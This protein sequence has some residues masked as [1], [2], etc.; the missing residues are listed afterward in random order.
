[1]AFWS[2][3]AQTF[4]NAPKHW[5]AVELNPVGIPGADLLAVAVGLAEVA[6][7]PGNGMA[8]LR[9]FVYDDGIL[10][11]P[12]VIE[13][14]GKKTG[15]F[16]YGA[17]HADPAGH[18]T[19]ARSLLR[20]RENMNAV[21][22]AS[23]SVAPAKP[24]M[25]LEPIDTPFFRKPE[26][27]PGDASYSLWWSTPEDP[28]FTHSEDRRLL[29]RWFAALDG[30]GWLLFTAFLRDL[31]LA[32]LEDKKPVAMPAQPFLHPLEGPGE[33]SLLLH[34]GENEGAFLAFNEATTT[35][36]RRRT[37]LRLLANFAETYREAI[38]A[39]SIP[40]REQEQGQ[41]TWAG[42]RDR[43]LEQEAT[44]ASGLRVHSIDVKDGQ[45]VR[46][47]HAQTAADRSSRPALPSRE[48]LDFAMDLVDRVVARIGGAT[49]G[50]SDQQLGQPNAFPTMAVRAG[51]ALYERQLPYEDAEMAQGAAARLLDEWP[52]LEVAALLLD[53]AIRENGHRVDIFSVVVQNRAEGSTA[54][55]IQRY[56]SSGGR[57]ELL[58]NPS[59]SSR[60]PFLDPKTED[61]HPPDP[62]LQAFTEEIVKTIVADLTIL[63]P[64][65]MLGDDPQAVL[66]TPSAIL[67]LGAA[68]ERPRNIRFMLQGPIIAAMSCARAVSEEKDVR[69][70][71]YYFDDLVTRDGAPDRR[72]RLCVQRARDPQTGIF[73]LPYEGPR[74]G[75]AWK[76]RGPLLF[77]RWGGP[78][79]ESSGV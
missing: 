45:P 35:V 44:G 46:T 2:K 66:T 31:E 26:K 63:E 53:A 42:I 78:F 55:L 20:S 59:A 36:A 40:P 33:T 6:K 39:R 19:G 56:R 67:G 48:T 47:P 30:Y 22:Y 11:V 50:S 28:L 34:A 9:E 29:D 21:Y 79:L 77:R 69:F 65:G 5:P 64:S 7:A 17:D 54:D 24:A 43:A 60:S 18:Y 72:I 25:V 71:V 74:K 13:E 38:K 62:T 61:D 16:V 49:S 37:L 14:A 15:V 57:V 75:V 58:G 3:K 1:V 27:D 52:D 4:T 8:L 10:R 70:V 68:S 32:E 41:V 76:A 12:V 73:E 51:G 23:A